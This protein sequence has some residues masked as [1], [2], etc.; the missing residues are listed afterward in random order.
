MRPR[1]P[2][3]Q[4]SRVPAK[5]TLFSVEPAMLLFDHDPPPFTVRSTAPLVPTAQPVSGSAKHTSMRFSPEARIWRV[6]TRPPSSVRSTAPPFPTAE[7]VLGPVN[8][9]PFRVA[10]VPLPCA[11]Q[12]SPASVVWMI[13][14]ALP[15]AQPWRP[16]GRKN[17]L[18]RL[19]AVLLVWANQPV[20]G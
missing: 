19:R 9:T 1:S 8:H 3:A 13:T 10:A 5:A 7:P 11:T 16:S 20:S 18:F 17:T 2:T 14:P 4:P 6:H 12:V 15:T